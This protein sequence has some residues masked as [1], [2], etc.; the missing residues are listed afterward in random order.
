M[1]WLSEIDNNKI[2]KFKYF[3]HSNLHE[4]KH[5]YYNFNLNLFSICSLDGYVNI[6]TLYSKQLIQSIKEESSIDFC[7]LINNPIPSIIIYSKKNLELKGYSLNYSF[8]DSLHE[9]ILNPEIYND[10]FGFSYLIY[11]LDE[12]TIKFLPVPY[13]EQNKCKIYK[14]KEDISYFKLNRDNNEIYLLTNNNKKIKIIKL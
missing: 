4:I 1:Q 9:N 14:S 8:I 3:I 11:Q 2:I 12:K 7:F 5:I 10:S 6:Y 13:F